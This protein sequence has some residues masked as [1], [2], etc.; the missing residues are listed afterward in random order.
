MKGMNA[1]PHCKGDPCLTWRRKLFMGPLTAAHCRVCGYRVRPDIERSTVATALTWIPPFLLIFL[2]GAGLVDNPLPGTILA[3]CC[4]VLRFILYIVWV[5]LRA[6][7][8]TNSSMVEAGRAR[9]AAEKA[10]R[11]KPKGGKIAENG[12]GDER[13]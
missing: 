11:Q 13:I 6:D 8:L 5:P 9:I 7:E 12:P 3:L 2:L 1:C 10:A 4:I